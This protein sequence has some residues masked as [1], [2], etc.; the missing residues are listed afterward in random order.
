MGTAGGGFTAL[1]IEDD[2]KTL[3]M[4]RESLS[5]VG[6]RVRAAATGWEA[7]K[8]VKTGPI[9][10]VISEW[11]I[12]DMDGCSL[13]EKFM[14]DPAMQH[15][16]FVFIVP[17]GQRDK[18]VRVLRLGVDD[19]ITRPFD[20]IVMVARVQAV[21]ARR[22]AYEEMV[23]IDPLTRVL[24]RTSLEQDVGDELARA[25]RYDRFASL[26][27]LDLDDLGE[28]NR[29]YGPAIGDLLLTCLGGIILTNMRRADTAGRRYGEKFLLCLPETRKQDAVTLL[30]RILERFTA[31]ADAVAGLKA[32]FSA[33]IVE[34]PCDGTDFAVLNA[35]AEQAVA[36]AKRAGKS[37]TIMWDKDCFAS[38]AAVDAE[39]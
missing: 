14:V 24:N 21:L 38:E 25:A 2:A 1:V 10:V 33:G 27:V 18:Q 39:A 34:A 37:M 19:C 32:T 29:Q 23:R 3:M 4:V 13:R 16:P 7:L 8:Y 36:A 28:V 15:V 20:P 17:E 6:F 11:A 22:Q 26:A 12:A 35:Q 31:A 9:D 30:Q 5:R